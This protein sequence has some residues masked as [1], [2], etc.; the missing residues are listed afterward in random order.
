MVSEKIFLFLFLCKNSTPPS[1]WPHSSPINHDI[2][3][4][5]STKPEDAPCP[6]QVSGFLVFEKIFKEFPLS[7]PM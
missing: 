3:K 7:I 5:E 6:T 1:L 2:N 4:L